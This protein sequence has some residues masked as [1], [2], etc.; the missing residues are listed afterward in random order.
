MVDE[1]LVKELDTP[2]LMAIMVVI[3]PKVITGNV[4]IIGG[5]Q[6]SSSPTA[7]NIR[8]PKII[9]GISTTINIMVNIFGLV[10][11]LNQRID[12][13]IPNKNKIPDNMN[14]AAPRAIFRL[15]KTDENPPA[16]GSTGSPIPAR[17]IKRRPS[18]NDNNPNMMM[19]KAVNTTRNFEY[20][21]LFISAF[22]LLNIPGKAITLKFIIVIIPMI[23]LKIRGHVTIV[24]CFIK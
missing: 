19:N 6:C 8:D 21:A 17:T 4:I 7:W 15:F 2:T 16:I 18:K 12:V 14:M 13:Y 3:D 22:G 5:S 1:S 23:L 24:Y 20:L 10:L 11:P 9:Q